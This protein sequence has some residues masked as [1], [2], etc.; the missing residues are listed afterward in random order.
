MSVGVII[1]TAAAS[2]IIDALL[3]GIAVYVFAI[4]FGWNLSSRKLPLL[5][6]LIFALL[7]LY[8]IPAVMVLDAT[9]TVRNQ[10]IAQ[11]LGFSQHTPLI[12]LF[13][14]GWYQVLFWLAQSLLALWVASKLRGSKSV[15]AS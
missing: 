4:R 10:S 7:D 12:E 11:L 2:Y 15:V 5:L 9:F 8:V 1:T 6:F 14:F 3:V 13:G